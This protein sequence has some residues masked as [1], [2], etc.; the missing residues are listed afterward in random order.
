MLTKELI[1]KSVRD[2]HSV[3]RHPLFVSEDFE[4]IRRDVE[5]ITTLFAVALGNILIQ[6]IRGVAQSLLL[7]IAKSF[8]NGR[9]IYLFGP[10]QSEPIRRRKEPL[11]LIRF[12]T[13]RFDMARKRCRERL[14]I[15]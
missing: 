13:L 4:T 7:A 11:N 14:A 15:G 3:R 5:I 2:E 1:P 12:A 10:T 8:G 9:S 6:T